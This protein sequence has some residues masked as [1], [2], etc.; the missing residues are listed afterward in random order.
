MNVLDYY[1]TRPGLECEKNDAT[2]QRVVYGAYNLGKIA[3]QYVHSNMGS[4]VVSDIAQRRSAKGS[5][6]ER[7]IDWPAG[8]EAAVT[9][10]CISLDLRTKPVR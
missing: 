1:F 3:I 2:H 5:K 6:A 7:S 9:K 4:M 8:L 10:E